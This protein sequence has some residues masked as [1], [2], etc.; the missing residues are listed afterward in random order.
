L[1][2]ESGSGQDLSKVSGRILSKKQI[3][4]TAGNTSSLVIDSIRD[5][6]SAEHLAVGWLYC[7]HESKNEQTVTDTI[8]AILRSLL[9]SRGQRDILDPESSKPQLQDLMR[10]LRNWLVLH[11][12]FICIDA[13]DE[14]PPENLPELLKSLG[15]IVR[16]FP[17]T[18]ILLTGRP[19]IKE[20]IQRHFVGAVEIPIRPNTN[21][22]RNY[23][24]MRLEKD[25]KPEAMD[26]NLR[27]DIGEVIMDKMSDR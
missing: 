19:H 15:D 11:Q 4:L 5:R 6:A 17:K 20:V 12:A 2:R 7:D 22:I 23:L 26:S 16:E 8:G 25:D 18:R 3:P 27:A 21:D 24:A 10:R 9:A 13:V 14:C 1:F